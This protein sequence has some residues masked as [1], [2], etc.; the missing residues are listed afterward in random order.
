MTRDPVFRDGGL[1]VEEQDNNYVKE[2]FKVVRPLGNG[3][4]ENH[5]QIFSGYI[6]ECNV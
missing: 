4:M 2:V 6:A 1:C 5:R 3:E